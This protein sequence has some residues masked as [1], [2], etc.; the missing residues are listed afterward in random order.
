MPLLLFVGLRLDCVSPAVKQLFSD[1]HLIAGGA[2]YNEVTQRREAVLPVDV[3]LFGFSCTSM[4][5]LNGNP[6][7]FRDLA[8]ASGG[9]YVRYLF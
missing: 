9:T 7:A 8:S 5:R 2:G 4:S 1:I 6:Q 3:V